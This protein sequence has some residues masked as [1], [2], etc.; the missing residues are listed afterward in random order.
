MATKIKR[1]VID[2]KTYRQCIEPGCEDFF[3]EH[4]FVPR[5][6]PCDSK[7]RREKREADNQKLF[8]DE[9]HPIFKKRRKIQRRVRDGIKEV[10]CTG[11]GNWVGDNP[12]EST[13]GRCRQC[14]RD[15]Y[16]A[17][18]RSKAEERRENRLPVDEISLKLAERELKGDLPIK[19]GLF[20]GV[21]EKTK[22]ALISGD[23]KAFMSA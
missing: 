2:G 8:G 9:F 14:H 3:V 18:N 22:Q 15:H 12:I 10:L 6:A 20:A 21:S 13:Y 19:G 1:K 11:C 5:C 23:F 4:A 17:Y 16:N 7:I